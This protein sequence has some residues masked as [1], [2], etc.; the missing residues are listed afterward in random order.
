M[1]SW[2]TGSCASRS[3][4]NDLGQQFTASSTLGAWVVG[5][6][7]DAVRDNTSVFSINALMSSWSTG[8]CASRSCVNDLGQQF[9][10]S[11]TLGAWVVGSPQDAVRDNTSVFS[12]NALMSS[13]STGSCASCSC[14]NDL[15]QQFTASSTLGA[16]VVGSPQDAVRVN[17]KV[18]SI[19]ALMNSWSTGSCASRSCV[20][21]L[22]QQYTV[23]GITKG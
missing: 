4:V 23:V 6:P 18:F 21:G 10:A 16:W 1:S 2:S 7:Q 9:T 11:S 8:S 22:G 14:V 20:N 13:W 5:S 19:N 17:T 12:I 15:G 3:C